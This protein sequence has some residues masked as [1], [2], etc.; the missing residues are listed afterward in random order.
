MTYES[1]LFTKAF[2]SSDRVVC[3]KAGRQY[4]LPFGDSVFDFVFLNGV[5][6]WIPEGYMTEENPRDVQ[7]KFLKLTSLIYQSV[8]SHHLRLTTGALTLLLAAVQVFILGL[9][10]DL[11]VKRRR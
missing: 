8:V 5:L 6:E 10:A 7:V 4:P 2:S 1:L 9:L 11:I 3:V